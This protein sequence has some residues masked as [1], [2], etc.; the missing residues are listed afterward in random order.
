MTARTRCGWI[1]AMECG[2]LLFG[3]WYPL[4]LKGAVYKIQQFYM[5]VK[6]GA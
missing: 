3:N 4:K 5:Y 6:H 2:E 1:K